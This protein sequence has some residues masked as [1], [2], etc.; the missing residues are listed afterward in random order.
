MLASVVK[1]TT[2]NAGITSQATKAGVPSNKIIV[3]V[4]SYGRS[5]AMSDADCHGPEC[6]FLGTPG[7]SPATPGQCTQTAGYIA[8]AEINAILQD[9]SRV[10]Q[11]Y[12]DPTSNSNILVYD[13]TQW[14]AYMDDDTKSSRSQVYQS[15]AMGGVTDWAVDLQQYNDPPARSNSWLQ[16]TS[17]VKSG[18]DPA[19]V[20]ERTGNWSSL[21]CTDAS[22]TDIRDLSPQERWAEMDASNAW[23]DLINVWETIDRP[24]GSLTFS[25]SISDTIHGLENADCGAITGSSCASTILCL[26]GEGSGPAGYEIWNSFVYINE[27][28]RS[29]HYNKSID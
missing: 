7:S 4:T 8:N 6:T 22:V 9:S 1:G 13:N 10:N 24:A 23:S 26:Q 18:G 5:F 14:V 12:V 16:F 3:G 17:K 29:S 27:A 20:G 2:T 11:H 15:W 25:E 28:S 21:N 19:D